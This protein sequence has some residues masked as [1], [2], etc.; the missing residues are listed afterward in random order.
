MMLR[1]QNCRGRGDPHPVGD[2]PDQ[3]SAK[4]QENPMETLFCLPEQ[5]WVL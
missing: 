2:A 5:C 3:D 4:S 1:A